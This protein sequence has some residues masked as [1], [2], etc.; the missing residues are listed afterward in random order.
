AHICDHLQFED[1]YL[2]FAVAAVLPAPRS[3][4]VSRGEMLVAASAAPAF[5]G[6]PKLVWFYQVDKNFAVFSGHSSTLGHT[7][8]YIL[9]VTAGAL[10]TASMVAALGNVLRARTH[11]QQRV[12][13]G[14]NLQINVAAAAS[15][16]AIRAAT[17][18]V[19]FTAE[20]DATVAAVTGLD[21][22]FYIID[23][24]RKP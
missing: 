16:A 1:K 9:S 7:Y 3:F 24:H 21:V 11:I 12:D 17:G 23:K 8:Y 18:H 6:H 14:I 20:A 19:F 5:G 13:L 10:V 15:I 22:Y 2:V 4:V